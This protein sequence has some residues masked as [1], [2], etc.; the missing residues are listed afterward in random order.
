[1]TFFN[2]ENGFVVLKVKARGHREPVAVVGS[3]P[4]ANPGE[5]LTAEGRWVR[6]REFGL[7]FRADLLKSSAPTTREGIEKYLGSGMVKGIGPIYAKKLVAKFGE[8]IFEIIEKESGRLE[9]V[10][11]IGPMRRRRIKDAWAEQKSFVT[12]WSSCIRT[13]SAPAGRCVFT[14]RT[15][16]TRFELVRANPYKLAHDIPGIGFKSAD[17]IAQKI[18]IPHDSILRACAGLAHVLQEATGQGHCGLPV[19]LLKEEAGKLLLVDEAIVQTALERTL[20]ERKLI[21]EKVGDEALVLLPML[22]RAEEGIATRIKRLAGDTARSA[23][24]AAIAAPNYP[25]IDFEKAVAWCQT[26]TGKELAPTQRDALKQALSNRVLIITG[27]PGV[28]KNNFG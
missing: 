14:R 18:G 6:D 22:Q 24:N 19:E 2:D 20:N 5:W 16:R 26:K 28:G 10:E 13:A 8:K 11:G 4:S 27:G 23:S 7:Q 21:W 25:P 12:S 15:E 1:V 3:L 9:D 17:Q